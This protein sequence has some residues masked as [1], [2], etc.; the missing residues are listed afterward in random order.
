MTNAP[1]GRTYMKKK[2]VLDPDI[3]SGKRPS[4][5]HHSY[6][7]GDEYVIEETPFVV[8]NGKWVVE[9]PLISG[10]WSWLVGIDHSEL[11]QVTLHSLYGTYEVLYISD[12]PFGYVCVDGEDVDQSV[13]PN[14]VKASGRKILEYARQ[15]HKGELG[16][17]VNTPT[18]DYVREPLAPHRGHGMK[19]RER[20]RG[21]YGWVKLGNLGE[22]ARVGYNHP[23]HIEL[24]LGFWQFSGHLHWQ[25]GQRAGTLVDVAWG[26]GLDIQ[27]GTAEFKSLTQEQFREECSD[28]SEVWVRRGFAYTILRLQALGV[29]PTVLHTT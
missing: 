7:D 10:Y 24:I 14:E 22:M 18:L 5:H 4:R 27:L 6:Y 9:R 15:V 13:Y 29:Q 20:R 23:D 2:W 8:P 11:E 26:S 16:R 21:Q 17:G 12:K 28:T 19:A 3:E 25:N 1:E